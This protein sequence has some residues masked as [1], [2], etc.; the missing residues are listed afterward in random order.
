MTINQLSKSTGLPVSTIRF[1]EKRGL[2]AQPKRKANNYRDYSDNHI[3]NL[4]AISTLT[5]LGFSLDSIK[6]FFK[7]GKNQKIDSKR[8]MGVLLKQRDQINA[9]IESLTKINE[10]VTE[11]IADFKDYEGIIVDYWTLLASLFNEKQEA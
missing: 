3:F 2:L 1:Y 5:K 8:L 7:I 6:K 11:I 4:K 10:R 9:K